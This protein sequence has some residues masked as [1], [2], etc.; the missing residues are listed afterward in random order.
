MIHQ[1]VKEFFTATATK[2]AEFLSGVV[3]ESFH[4]VNTALG[5]PRL[6]RE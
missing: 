6:R 4:G 5:L 2:F 1:L 3:F